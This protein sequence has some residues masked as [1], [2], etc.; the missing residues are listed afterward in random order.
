M[1][2]HVGVYVC[3]GV[4]VGVCSRVCIHVHVHVCVCSRVC[5]G[6]EGGVYMYVCVGGGVWV[7]I[8]SMCV[9]VSVCAHNNLLCQQV[10]AIE[11]ALRMITG[12]YLPPRD[13]DS[14]S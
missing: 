2:V 6:G 9:C 14:L 13:L 1:C 3:V 8:H 4:H 5:V 10:E 12:R 11:P 7:C